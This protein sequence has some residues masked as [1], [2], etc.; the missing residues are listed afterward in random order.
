MSFLLKLFS[1]APQFES[2]SYENN[3]YT[4]KECAVRDCGLAYRG[5]GRDK[6]VIVDYGFKIRQFSP[7]NSFALKLK[8][9]FHS[10]FGSQLYLESIPQTAVCAS[11]D[12]AVATLFPIWNKSTNVYVFRAVRAIPLYE[13]IKE[14]GNIK[15]T[16][17]ISSHIISALEID[18]DEVPPKDILGYWRVTKQNCSDGRTKSYDAFFSDFHQCCEHLSE[19]EKLKIDQVSKQS[20][21]L[22]DDTIKDVIYWNWS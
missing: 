3:Q 16:G 14:L 18:S 7:T 19:Y 21:T 6:D 5:D 10:P 8:D 1:S 11:Q 17:F 2:W 13:T 12:A 15:S 20:M 9:V 22:F 4:A